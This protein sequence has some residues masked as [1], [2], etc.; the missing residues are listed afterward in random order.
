[1]PLDRFAA[2]LPRP[3][4]RAAAALCLLLGAQPLAAAPA[5]SCSVA[6]GSF[7]AAGAD[8]D[9]SLPGNA[10]AEQ[11][12]LQKISAP[13]AD[14]VV[15]LDGTCLYALS[16]DPAEP[17]ARS[18]D[19]APSGISLRGIRRLEGNGAI[20][21]RRGEAAFRLLDAA[22]PITIRNLT[23]SNGRHRRG[24]GL[25]AT[26][27]VTLENMTF[28]GNVADSRGGAIFLSGGGRLTIRNSRFIANQADTGAVFQCGDGDR[29]RRAQTGVTWEIANSI[30]VDNIAT[31][32]APGNAAL[33][34][35]D[36]ATGRVDGNVFHG[37]VLRDTLVAQVVGALSF[38][39]NIVSNHRWGL[40]WS[41]PG[42]RGTQ[43]GPA[44]SEDHN[45]FAA[46]GAT[47]AAEAARAARAA[48]A[49]RDDGLSEFERRLRDGAPPPPPAMGLLKPGGLS[50]RAFDAAQ[51][52][53]G[54]HDLVAEDAH[55]MDAGALDFRLTGRS[56]AID[57]G[58]RGGAETDAAGAARPHGGSAPDIGAFEFTPG[59]ILRVESHGSPWV[60]HGLGLH[61]AVA[62][63]NL[64]DRAAAGVTVRQE[65]PPGVRAAQIS[66]GGRFDADAVT[67]TLPRLGA[68]AG[69]LLTYTAAL[70]D[71]G[72]DGAA[73]DAEGAT[74]AA[75]D[76]TVTAAAARRWSAVVNP[77]ITA[78]MDLLPGLDAFA[79]KNI[80]G[81]LDTDLTTAD[82]V[83]LFGRSA[84][85]DPGAAT[86]TLRPEREMWRRERLDFLSGGH[87]VGMAEGA[88]SLRYGRLD[89][90]GL[91]RNAARLDAGA[92]GAA[93]L[94]KPAARRMITRFAAAQLL[95]PV[96]TR[97]LIAAGL[98]PFNHRGTAGDA[99]RSPFA[100]APIASLPALFKAN[101][102]APSPADRY[103]LGVANRDLGG[104]H[105]LLPWALEEDGAGIAKIHVH[106]SNAPDE[107]DLF[108]EIDTRAG[109]WRYAPAYAAHA[110][111]P[112]DWQGDAGTGSLTLSSF[113]HAVSLPKCDYNTTGYC[114]SDVAG[115]PAA[116]ATVEV[117]L[118][119]PGY[120]TVTRSD[121]KTAGLDAQG[122]WSSEIEGAAALPVAVGA[123]GFRGPLISIPHEPG[124]TYSM[125]LFPRAELPDAAPRAGR[126]HVSGPR[127][128]A[129]IDG[130]IL[131]YQRGWDQA[132]TTVSAAPDA[133]RIGLRS[134]VAQQVDMELGASRADGS[135][136]LVSLAAHGI[137]PKGG[138]DMAWDAASDA[139]ALR[140]GD[141]APTQFALTVASIG[142]DGGVDTRSMVASD[143][144]AELELELELEVDV[145]A[146]VVATPVT[147][148]REEIDRHF[149][150]TPDAP[151]RFMLES[152]ETPARVLAVSAEGAAVLAPLPYGRA[153]AA[154]V[155]EL[156][157]A[158][159]E[160][161]DRTYAIRESR[162][163]RR[164]LQLAETPGGGV[165]LV[166]AA[167][168]E[169]PL[170][171]GAAIRVEEVSARTEEMWI[172][173]TATPPA[174]RMLAYDA[175]GRM[176]LV[177]LE[178]ERA[179]DGA[180][181][182]FRML[183]VE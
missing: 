39:N 29:A 82:V 157:P 183:R 98:L 109:T 137:A 9:A 164:V 180:T 43:P 154:F 141:H 26:G 120:V 6:A 84:C 48:P 144:G 93:D 95:I 44:V 89:D 63:R 68:G 105:R 25:L 102:T 88:L 91:D 17:G 72:T 129:T 11:D 60:R 34:D 130:V 4:F 55:F 153:R 90:P 145:G 135:G 67:W 127:F 171:E 176:R 24:A 15:E 151:F 136:V 100:K 56:A 27:D 7:C 170:P 83:G 59:P 177:D 78:Q 81:S 158:G 139:L 122:T 140:D 79:F 54:G 142:A 179:L 20:I 132:L 148:P 52:A 113:A 126:L 33:E 37:A 103:T 128:A 118:S 70:E 5:E 12:L 152:R 111:P 49:G 161:L 85:V 86:C 166:A 46:P 8:P 107:T 181:F 182:Q 124:M 58:A 117:M 159:A 123:R 61:F 30:F 97:A 175:A 167:V 150:A 14:G 172:L 57:A 35:C 22:G 173:S 62:V 133:G 99:A 73:L 178:D 162:G 116:P 138:L 112:V 165:G 10:C 32:R 131:A 77:R 69:K 71:P 106:D 66:D 3:A 174:Y 134:D 50:P 160:G 53:P 51:I 146:R 41:P 75:A 19:D 163:A 23:L 18:G 13:D 114:P 31:S 147:G 101:F 21:L 143:D 36:D 115:A 16:A 76:G 80:S 149:A 92:V 119:G 87:C 125:A 45:L 40:R 28:L 104:G 42:E 38:R 65:L 94:S 155:F 47:A 156:E 74:A 1:M 96:K 121:G 64:G 108:I 169:G 2:S 168:E 110:V